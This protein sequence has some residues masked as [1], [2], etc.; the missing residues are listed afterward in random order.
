MIDGSHLQTLPL[1]TDSSK[2]IQGTIKDR[3]EDFQVEEI[4]LYDAGGDGPHLYFEMTKRNMTTDAA[5]KVLA[6]HFGRSPREFGVAGKK[7]KQALT[8]QRISLEHVG[9]EDVE[10]FEHDRIKLTVIDRHRNKIQ[11]GHLEANKFTVKIRTAKPDQSRSVV[12]DSLQKL[13]DRGVPNYFGSQRFGRR[14]DTDDLGEAMVQGELDEFLELYFGRPSE[15]DPDDVRRAR[16]LFERENYEEAIDAWPREYSNKRSGLAAYIDRR[17]PGPVLSAL[18]KSRR[19]LFLSA[20]QSRLFNEL[21]AERMP[22][23]NRVLEGDIAKKTD[24]GG[25]FEVE[26]PDQEQPRADR[27]EI[28]PTGLLPGRDPWYASGEPGARERSLLDENDVSEEDFEKVGYLRSDGTRRP[29]RFSP[30]SPEVESRSDE[31]GPYLNLTFRI[32]SGCYATVLL[33][34]VLEFD[35]SP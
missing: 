18:S 11:P 21:L 32:P 15:A 6:D 25:M 31:H 27:F 26:E 34:E 30:G 28:S 22:E 4:P 17:S 14:R 35:G 20:Y 19:Q 24:T 5:V 16:E 7:D 1:L 23:V 12:T 33:R 29:Y 10:S 13:S 9:A 2:R 3:P 8:T